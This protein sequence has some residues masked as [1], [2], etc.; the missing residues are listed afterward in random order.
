MAGVPDK[1]TLDGIEARWAEVWDATGVYRF[2]RTADTRRGVRRRHP[3]ADGVGVAAHGHDLRLHAVRRHGPL[4]AD[5]RQAGLLPDRLGRQRPRHRAPRP[6]LLRRPVRP[7]AAVRRRTSRRRTAATSRRAPTSCPIS[8]P[9]FVELCHEL[10][11]TDEAVFED[12]ASAASGCRSTGPCCTRRSARRAGGSAR[13]RSCATSPAARRTAP[14]RRRCGTSTTRPRSPRRRSRTASVPAPTTASPST[15]PIGVW[16]GPGSTTSS[17]RRRGPELIVSCVALVAHPD[18]ERYQP[19]FGT[20]VRTPLFDV[21]VPV[22]AH[23]LADPD[24]GTGHRD[25]VHVRRRHR[26]HVVARA[27]PADT[28]R[29]RPRRPIQ[30]RRLRT[31]SSAQRGRGRL[32][33]P[34]P[35]APSSRPRRP[36]SR[37]CAS[38]A[39]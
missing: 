8:R 17:S 2:D 37:R 15:L 5:A 23:P 12:G 18:D 28:Q 27:R 30:R 26:R 25:D 32:R 34:S 9:N 39:S 13:R 6:E 38:P 11:A 22:V 29:D 16:A 35:A 36:R 33:A 31:G 7:G 3:A 4:P 20:S 10:T 14:M 1:P 19:R 21:E 24:K